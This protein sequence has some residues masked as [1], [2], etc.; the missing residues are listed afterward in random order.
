M[1]ETILV[2]TTDSKSQLYEHLS[3]VVGF[4][5]NILILLDFKEKLD[6]F[7]AETCLHSVTTI[8]LEHNDYKLLRE[9]IEMEK[10]ISNIFLAKITIHMF[11]LLNYLV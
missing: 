3:N 1:G 7:S 6:P 10:S 11:G 4:N 8:K 5:V 2:D 9:G